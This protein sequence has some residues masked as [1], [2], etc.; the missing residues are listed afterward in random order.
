M[1]KYFISKCVNASNG[2]LRSG[3][4]RTSVNIAEGN[5]ITESTLLRREQNSLAFAFNSFVQF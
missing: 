2:E 3:L 4:G 1:L 5:T